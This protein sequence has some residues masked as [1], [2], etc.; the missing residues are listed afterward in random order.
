M[1]R[2]VCDNPGLSMVTYSIKAQET[3]KSSIDNSE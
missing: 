1:H 2:N 3:P